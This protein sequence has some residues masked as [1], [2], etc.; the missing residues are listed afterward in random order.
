MRNTNRVS[1]ITSAILLVIS[2]TASCISLNSNLK[3]DQSKKRTSAPADAF[4]LVE[5]DQ[6]LIPTECKTSD[7]EVDCEKLISELPRIKNSGSGSGLMVMSDAGP[8][9]LTA[10]HV[11]ESD[12]P[13]TF[14]HRG[15]EIT[16][17]TMT[18]IKVHSPLKGSYHADILRTD[19]V[20]DLCLLRPEKI[21]THPVPLAKREPS[22]GEKVYAVAAPFGISGKNL[23]LVFSGFFSGTRENTR[24]YTIPTRPGS[25]GSAVLNEN[26]EVVGVLHTA[27]RDLENVGLGTGLHD[28][29]TFL[30]SPVEVIVETP[31]F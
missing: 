17:L 23:A 11:C 15:I 24:F 26:W 18:K 5:I 29:K 4:V 19:R 31:D 21:F 6:E 13:D 8:A 14:K 27:F 28:I 22:I 9:I 20:K 25:S 3:Y 1:L 7:P 16:I 10:A 2:I 30:F 12:A